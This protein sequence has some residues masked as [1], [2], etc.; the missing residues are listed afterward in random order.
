M[1]KLQKKAKQWQ[2]HK[3][4]HRMAAILSRFKN[5]LTSKEAAVKNNFGHGTNK[6][7][8]VV[9]DQSGRKDPTTFAYKV[10]KP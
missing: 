10:A 6:H 3:I 9:L 2:I 7:T 1:E 8:K 5:N 4:G